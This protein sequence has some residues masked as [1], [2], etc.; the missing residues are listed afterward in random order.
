MRIPTTVKGFIAGTVGLAALQ[1]L[2]GTQN[3]PKAFGTAVDAPMQ[4]FANLADPGV[5]LVPDLRSQGGSGSSSGGQSDPCAGLVGFA[6]SVCQAQHSAYY[7]SGSSL[8]T[9]SG[10]AST[11]PPGYQLT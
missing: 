5:P 10:S 11:L 7:S 8:G 9:T 3:G 2:T 1:L 6:Q 4:L